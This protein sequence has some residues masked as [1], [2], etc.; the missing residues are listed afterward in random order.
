ML[1]AIS[2][3][4]GLRCRGPPHPLASDL[5]SKSKVTSRYLSS[6]CEFFSG[7]FHA[8][9][10]G[11]A[12]AKSSSA[13]LKESADI[14]EVGCPPFRV[15]G[16]RY[17]NSGCYYRSLVPKLRLVQ[18]NTSSRSFLLGHLQAVTRHLDLI[19]SLSQRPNCFPFFGGFFPR[20]SSSVLRQASC[21]EKARQF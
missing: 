13:A 9:L 15:G 4:L 20:T 7:L 6:G 16:A 14:H 10:R 11:K 1:D 12:G 17:Q 21:S 5:P 8:Q 18:C 2:D 3:E 19:G